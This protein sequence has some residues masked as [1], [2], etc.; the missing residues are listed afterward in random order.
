[1]KRL[2]CRFES[3]VFRAVFQGRW[4]GRADP[5]LAAHVAHCAICSDIVT[6]AGAIEESR[7]ET[8]APP[9]IPNSGLVWWM[10]Q[11]RARLE[12]A[13]IAARPIQAAQA[14]ALV[15]AAILFCAYSGA[16]VSRFVAALARLSPDKGDLDI[17]A[18]LSAAASLLAGHAGLALA[19]AAVLLLV[20]AAAYLAIGRD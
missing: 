19:A 13:E 1:M 16:V 11:R 20:P 6:V 17:A 8:A 12:A 4:P 18:R 15:C 5:D 3:E 2:E 10:A 9:A 14:I 7:E